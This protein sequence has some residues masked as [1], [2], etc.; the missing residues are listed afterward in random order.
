ML[1]REH[2]QP[3]VPEQQQCQR[4]QFVE[5]FWVWLARLFQRCDNRSFWLWVAQR[6]GGIFEPAELETPRRLV[7]LTG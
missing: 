3:P 2:G 4:L 7:T 6:F 1:L 5:K